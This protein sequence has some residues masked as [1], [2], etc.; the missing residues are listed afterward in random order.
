MKPSSN[1]ELP[2][3]GVQNIGLSLAS[4][5][6]FSLDEPSFGKQHSRVVNKSKP[7]LAMPSMDDFD[8]DEDD[9]D[10]DDIPD[11]SLK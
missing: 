4:G 11:L 10:I 6:D 7:G 5:A 9:M 2:K 3:F 1:I 8:L